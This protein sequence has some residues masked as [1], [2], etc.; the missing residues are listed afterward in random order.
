MRRI[1]LL[2]VWVALM[3]IPAIGLADLTQ[4]DRLMQRPEWDGAVMQGPWIEGAL[5]FQEWDSDLG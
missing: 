1:I 4:N 5:S 2:S 3:A